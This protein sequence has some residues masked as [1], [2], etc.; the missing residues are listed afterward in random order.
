MS[1]PEL[2]VLVGVDFSQESRRALR[3]AR[4][5][6]RS[7]GGTI[8]IAHIRPL[9]DVK[10]VVVEERGDL[11]RRPAGGLARAMAIHYAR[12]LERVRGRGERVLLLKGAPGPVLCREARRGYDILVLGNRGRGRIAASLLGSTVQVA[13]LRSPVPVLVVRRG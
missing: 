7:C 1:R 2:R 10:A 13:L 6:A 5:L 11:L 9:S 4:D 3:V 12:R 8:T